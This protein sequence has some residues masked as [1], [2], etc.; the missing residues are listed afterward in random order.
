MAGESRGISLFILNRLIFVEI[1][2]LPPHSFVYKI[3]VLAPI[4]SV[5]LALVC[6]FVSFA[7]EALLYRFSTVR[8]HRKLH[9]RM[10]H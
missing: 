6:N 1:I 9:V 5:Q 3:V 7:L 8:F 2:E 10:S 4:R